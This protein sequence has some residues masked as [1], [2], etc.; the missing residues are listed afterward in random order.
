MGENIELFLGFLEKNNFTI[1]KSFVD[2]FLDK[3]LSYFKFEVVDENNFLQIYN[4]LKGCNTKLSESYWILRKSETIENAI[5]NKNLYIEDF[6][7]SSYSKS[8]RKDVQFKTNK[9]NNSRG[10]SGWITIYDKDFYVRS[11][12]EFIFL[13]Y[14]IEVDGVKAE[15]VKYESEIYIINGSSYKPDFFIFDGYRLIKI[16]EIKGDKKY[17]LSD[18]NL[19]I[20]KFF[21]SKGISYELIDDFKQYK[22][23]SIEKDLEEWKLRDNKDVSMKGSMNPM[24]GV[25][26]SDKTKELI[27]KKAKERMEDGDYKLRVSNGLKEYYKNNEEARKKVGETT[28]RNYKTFS[29]EKKKD[30]VDRTKKTV[31]EKYYETKYCL[32]GCGKSMVVKKPKDYC[33]K[34]C[35]R[36]ITLANYGGLLKNVIIKNFI[37]SW[38][39][40][41]GVGEVVSSLETNFKE[42]VR[43]R[44]RFVNNRNSIF[45]IKIINE[46][47]GSLEN[48]I[49][50][51][52]EEKIII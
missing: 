3:T 24:Y 34:K 29:D 26:H 16:Y 1:R 33:C 39:L 20:Q 31:L 2:K 42:K 46:T 22:T 32:G 37:N 44:K 14:L 51:I 52:K 19:E 12:F 40:D 47:Y 7:K 9:I 35:G 15:D 36:R 6:K 28:S 11:S 38:I 18:R 41:V 25:K 45:G 13:K 43:E 10:Y 30:I 21:D 27:G 49:L 17:R 4:F 8:N 48:L 50:K 23:P 5:I